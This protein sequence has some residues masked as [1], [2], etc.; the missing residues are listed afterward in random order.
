MQSVTNP[1]PATLPSDLNGVDNPTSQAQKPWRTPHLSML[2]LEQT[3][4]NISTSEFFTS[5]PKGG[6]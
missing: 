3:Q 2:K 5:G 6:S 1:N 4:K